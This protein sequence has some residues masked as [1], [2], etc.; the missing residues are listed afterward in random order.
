[1]RSLRSLASRI[2]GTNSSRR[3]S[4]AAHPRQS[5]V[6][7]PSTRVADGDRRLRHRALLVEIRHR[8]LNQRV[9]FQRDMILLHRC[10]HPC[11]HP[12]SPRRLLTRARTLTPRRGRSQCHGRSV[13]VLHVVIPAT[14]LKS[15]CCSLAMIR[16][17]ITTRMTRPHWCLP[18]TV[19]ARAVV[20]AR[21]H[22]RGGTIELSHAPAMKRT[23]PTSP[24]GSI[25]LPTV[26]LSTPTPAHPQTQPYPRF[27]PF[28]LHS[29]SKH[30]LL[31]QDWI[32]GASEES[33]PSITNSSSSSPSRSPSLNPAEP[34]SST[35][36]I[37]LGLM[38]M[39]RVT[40]QYIILTISTWSTGTHTRLIK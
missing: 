33:T 18:C 31:S 35:R 7:S 13:H 27:N 20:R 1:M 14:K 17:V 8:A 37:P 2:C 26:P 25:A 10:V 4:L 38:S 5:V 12:R 19:V 32:S 11:M 15:H 40:H 16:T 39:E 28:P 3:S 29:S 36:L 22:I 24:F 21:N 30:Q 9:P 23:P 6:F 34:L